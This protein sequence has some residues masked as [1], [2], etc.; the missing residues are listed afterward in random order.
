R[1]HA[2]HA[3]DVGAVLGVGEVAPARKLIALLPVLAPALAVGLS[4]DRRVAAVGT[5]DAPG[6]QYD[7]DGAQDVLD[8]VAV[9]L[10]PARM[11]EEARLRRAPPFGC[12]VDRLHR[13]AGHLGRA[14]GRP[15]AHVRG[16]VVESDGVLL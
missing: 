15:L 13:D 4:R 14:L 1:I 11:T 2:P 9:M 10:E 16:D 8:A 6:G 5:T 7:V 12:L 3:G